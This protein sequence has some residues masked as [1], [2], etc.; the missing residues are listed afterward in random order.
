MNYNFANDTHSQSN[1][2][3]DAGSIM[4]N[5]YWWMTAGLFMTALV[6]WGVAS[7]PALF[8]TLNS[9]MGQIIMIVGLFGLVFT[10]SGRIH[11][12]RAS[13]GVLLFSLYSC[14]MGAFLSTIFVVYTGAS[15]L[16][17][18][19]TTSVLFLSM[20]LYGSVTKRSLD[21]LGKYFLFGLWGI[22]IASL[23]NFFLGSPQIA[24]LISGVGVILFLGLTAYDTQAILRMAREAD[25]S[26][27]ENFTRLSLIGALKLYLDFIN[28][29]LF[30]LRFMGRGK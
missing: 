14:L 8:Y 12:L 30:L 22:I 17:T 1:A 19:L 27:N 9:G 2:R 26:D 20:S 24:Y 7:N 13:T 25:I 16:S 5:V 11:K 4:R 15:I 21:S 3:I 10:I 23:I 29:F 28:L 6:A 18:F